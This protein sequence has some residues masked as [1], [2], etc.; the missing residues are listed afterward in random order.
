MSSISSS[1]LTTLIS[2]IK[3]NEIDAKITAPNITGA[4][5]KIDA[6]D[7]N[8]ALTAVLEAISQANDST[9]N[10]LDTLT[11]VYVTGTLLDI[12]DEL[13]LELD[14]KH[15]LINPINTAF[16]KNF[17]TSGSSVVVP[18]LDDVRFSDERVPINNTVSTIKVQDNAINNNKLSDMLGFT[19]K[20]NNQSTLQSPKDLTA[21]EVRTVLNIEDGSQVNYSAKNSVM[22]DIDDTYQLVGDTDETAIGEFYYYGSDASETRGFYSI[23]DAIDEYISLNGGDDWG[24]QVVEIEEDIISP[25]TNT[26]TILSGSGLLTDKLTIESN[27]LTSFITDVITSV[28]PGDDWGEQKVNVGTDT[29][30]VGNGADIPLSLE[31]ISNES[32]TGFGTVDSELQVDEDW[33]TDYVTTILGTALGDDWGDQEAITSG[34]IE[35]DG[36]VATPIKLSPGSTSREILLWDSTTSAWITYAASALINLTQVY[37]GSNAPLT[38]SGTA[39][40]PLSFTNGTAD[41]DLLTWNT[42]SSKWVV[43]ALSDISVSATVI[44]DNVSMLGD[45]TT[46]DVLRLAEGTL[47]KDLLSWNSVA[48]VWEVKAPLNNLTTLGDNI[49][50]T[51]GT[52]GVL[53]QKG[54]LPGTNV[55]VTDNGVDLVI[56]AESPVHTTSINLANGVTNVYI[57][58]NLNVLYPTINIYVT[59]GGTIYTINNHGTSRVGYLDDLITTCVDANNVR[60]NFSATTAC[61]LYVKITP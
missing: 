58:H 19:F 51:A 16:N 25:L 52:T 57:P 14:S 41:D 21:G 30:I 22:L 7:H 54:I 29:G 17:G 56:A 24:E 11:G 45:G 39:S 42:T 40:S 23:L 55:T 61:D 26:Y 48:E 1:A 44:A 20:G 60:L 34:V 15:P 53:T 18:R 4:S 46:G 37:K 2:S 59:V 32:L 31:I 38:G 35:G 33:L 13:Q 9:Y 3:T 10:K 8:E 28:N 36:T 50:S 5:I 12:L 47:N 6:S 49:L 27:G 43:K